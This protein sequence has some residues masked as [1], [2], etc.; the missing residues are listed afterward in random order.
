VPNAILVRIEQA[1]LIDGTMVVIFKEK[2][3]YSSFLLNAH[4]KMID[5]AVNREN[6]NLHKVD[7]A[8][9]IHPTINNMLHVPVKKIK[10]IHVSI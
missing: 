1:P 8:K 5:L 3:F 2:L 4:P 9:W 6:L 10:W 7:Q